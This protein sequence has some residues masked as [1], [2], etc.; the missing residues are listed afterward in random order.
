[1]LSS[2]YYRVIIIIKWTSFTEAIENF[3]VSVSFLT[4]WS[5]WIHTWKPIVYLFQNVQ[6]INFYSLITNNVSNRGNTLWW[7]LLADS[8][9]RLTVLNQVCWR[10]G[11]K[12]NPL[13]MEDKR[14]MPFYPTHWRL[15]FVEK[16][17]LKINM[18]W[19]YTW[20]HK[21]NWNQHV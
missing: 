11:W 21:T 1:M 13:L 16:D 14:S 12:F 7:I 19:R 3:F 6:E 15:S 2:C 20:M 9:S 18:H 10:A 8:C 4:I 17:F 5:W